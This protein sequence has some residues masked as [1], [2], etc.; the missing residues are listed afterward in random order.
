MYKVLTFREITFREITMGIG[1]SKAHHQNDDFYLD[2]VFAEKVSSTDVT[3]NNKL[4]E[5]TRDLE[6]HHFPHVLANILHSPT[7]LTRVNGDR[8]FDMKKIDKDSKECIIYLHDSLSTIRSDTIKTMTSLADKLNR[9][10]YMLEYPGYGESRFLGVPDFKSC[11][12]V[13]LGTMSICEDHSDIYIIAHDIGAVVLT[14]VL[15]DD[16][17]P[18]IE[19]IILISPSEGTLYDNF[20]ID[21]PTLIIQAEDDNANIA[22]QNRKLSTRNPYVILSK[23]DANGS[24]I[25]ENEDT[26][27]CIKDFFELLYREKVKDAKSVQNNLSV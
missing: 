14:N 6:L 3:V 26:H 12:D 22:S 10:I 18:E 7:D 25:M 19:G 23:I 11:S 20:E 27:R 5:N 17:Y 15:E 21:Y 16:L 24:K 13:L 4:Q 9:T 8:T 2:S 1:Q